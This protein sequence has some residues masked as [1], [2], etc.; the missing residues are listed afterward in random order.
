MDMSGHQAVSVNSNTISLGITFPV[1]EITLVI[2]WLATIAFPAP[3]LALADE[4]TL[5]CYW[6]AG[7]YRELAL[8]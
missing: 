7:P 2:L 8:A 3:E 1:L 6:R 4:K 5:P